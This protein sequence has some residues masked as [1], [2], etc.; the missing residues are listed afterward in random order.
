[1]SPKITPLPRPKQRSLRALGVIASAFVVTALAASGGCSNFFGAGPDPAADGRVDASAVGGSGGCSPLA[2]LDPTGNGVGCEALYD[3]LRAHCDPELRSCFG[4]N[5]QS[6]SFSGSLCEGVTSCVLQNQ[7]SPG[8]SCA[9]AAKNGCPTC[10]TQLVSC[11]QSTCQGMCNGQG[12]SGSSGAITLVPNVQ[13]SAIALDP[14]TVYFATQQGLAKVGKDGTGEI[15][16]SALSQPSGLALDANNLYAIDGANNSLVALAKS[17]TPH[18]TTLGSWMCGGGPGSLVLDSSGIYLTSGPTLFKIPI[19]GGSVNFL[20]S[21]GS[22]NGGPGYGTRL[23][24]DDQY[25][26][27][28]AND[29]DGGV[30]PGHQAI[31]GILK[32]SALPGNG[33]SNQVGTHL[34]DADGTI[35]AVSLAA[36]QSEKVLFFSDLTSNGLTAILELRALILISPLRS[37]T[38]GTLAMLQAPTTSN[39]PTAGSP[40]IADPDGGYLYVA[41]FDGIY[42]IA[43]NI[44]SCGS[45]EMFVPGASASALAFDGQY[46]YYG[47]QSGGQNPPGLRKIAK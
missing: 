24:A 41:G 23:A 28:I 21:D 12:G 36:Q 17:G 40:I 7:C 25:A 20:A 16:L 4:S 2:S 32:T 18:Q 31:N 39:N 10:L 27:Y 42:R 38:A 26:Y 30:Q 29:Q 13:V 37:S 11:E 15:G 19:A 45:P 34:T 33:C 5:Y 14:D 8:N 3:C 6:Q 9:K 47:D 43:C 35:M 46:L 22:S 1:M 44:G